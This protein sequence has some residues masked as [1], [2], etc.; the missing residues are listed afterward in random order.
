MKLMR[1][2]FSSSVCKAVSLRGIREVRREEE[3]DSLQTRNPSRGY[4]GYCVNKLEKY[5]T[6][7]DNLI[8]EIL[9]RKH[10]NRKYDVEDDECKRFD[11]YI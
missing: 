11:I 9:E 3:E 5:F 2:S 10:S 4:K 1:E 6:I 7:F 8:R